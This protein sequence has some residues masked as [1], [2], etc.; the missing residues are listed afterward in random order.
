MPTRRLTFIFFA[1]AV[2]CSMVRE[3]GAPVAC[4]RSVLLASTMTRTSR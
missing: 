4:M 2:L 3:W 1:A